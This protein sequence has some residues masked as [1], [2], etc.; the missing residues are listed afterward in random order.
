MKVEC[1]TSNVPWFTEGKEYVASGFMLRVVDDA[2]DDWYLSE[3]CDIL[4]VAGND[5]ATFEEVP[6]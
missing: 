6:E 2:G 3:Y 1:V 4:V 5:D